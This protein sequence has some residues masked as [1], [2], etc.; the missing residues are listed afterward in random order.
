MAQKLTV[1]FECSACGGTGLYRGMCEGKGTAV[2]CLRCDGTGC[3]DLEYTPF[4]E[5]KPR[6][7]VEHVY[8]SRGTFIGTGVGPAGSSV[9]YEE[10]LQ[11]K[12]P[13]P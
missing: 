11:G 2:V 1:K 13:T 4:T 3:R 10:F 9:T 5:R 7:D 12:M 6:T 8:L